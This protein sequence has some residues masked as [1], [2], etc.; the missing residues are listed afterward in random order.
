MR[1]LENAVVVQCNHTL[2]GCGY[3][4]HSTVHDKGVNV[5]VGSALVCEVVN[6]FPFTRVESYNTLKFIEF[7][8]FRVFVRLEFM[9]PFCFW[10]IYL[11]I[12][13]TDILTY[14]SDVI[15]IV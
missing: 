5:I 14:R 1:V 15:N 2:K 12:E 13:Y 7:V 6:W 9:I 3:N 11:Y 4:W 8:F 10:E